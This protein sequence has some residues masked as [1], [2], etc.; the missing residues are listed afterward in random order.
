MEIDPTKTVED[1]ARKLIIICG[2]DASTKKP[3]PLVVNPTT[4]ELR[5][6]AEFTGD[7]VVDLDLPDAITGKT[8]SLTGGVADQLPNVA[9]KAGLSVQADDGNT[10]DVWVGG[11]DV[12]VNNGYKLSPGESVP[13]AAQNAN[14]VY[15][16][17]TTADK[18]HYI[19]G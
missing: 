9:L 12:A 14:L 18:V 15:V 8:V 17:G 16:I 13:M 3:F 4:G 6:N 19:A 1:Q 2:I 5:V 7:V 11:S 10:A